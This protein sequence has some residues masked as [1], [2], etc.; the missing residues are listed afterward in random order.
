MPN[1]WQS[2]VASDAGAAFTKPAYAS[3]R[4]IESANEHRV[5]RLLE[6]T[7]RFFEPRARGL[8]DIPGRWHT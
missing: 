4:T 7:Q 1:Q 5:G 6:R 3:K 2:G 8:G